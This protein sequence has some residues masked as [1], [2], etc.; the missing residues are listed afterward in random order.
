MCSRL[1]CLSFNYEI[2]SH[3]KNGDRKDTL[4]LRYDPL[5]TDERLSGNGTGLMDA[6]FDCIAGNL[7]SECIA[8]ALARMDFSVLSTLAGYPEQHI[9]SESSPDTTSKRTTR[10]A[11]RQS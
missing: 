1:E 11:K 9:V 4:R 8:I 10:R 6:V 5:R 2:T 7:C 3:E